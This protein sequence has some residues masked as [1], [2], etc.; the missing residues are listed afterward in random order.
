M[1]DVFLQIA[2]ISI[3]AGWI[4]IA[5]ILLR[6]LFKKAPKW[7]NCLL[8]GIVG[9][10]LVF[11][12]S[13]E[14]ALSLIPS[15]NTFTAPGFANEPNVS[16][17]TGFPAVDTAVNDYIDS[18]IFEGVSVS[19]TYFSDIMSVL[20]VIWVVGII[21][22]L[23]YAVISY[24]R[25]R[26][27]M[28]TS[29]PLRDNIRQSENVA[30]PFI[31]GIIKPK[32]YLPYSLDSDEAECIIAHEKAHLKRFDHIIKPLAFVILS[33][34]WFNPLIW[35]SYILLCRDI[36]LAC[37]EKVINSMVTEERQEYSVALLQNSVNRRT[38]SACPLAFGE[39]GIKERVKS[40]MSY[41]KPTLWIILIAVISCIIASV[42]F[43]TNPKT[44]SLKLKDVYINSATITDNFNP[45][46]EPYDLSEAEKLSLGN[47]LEKVKA[48]KKETDVEIGSPAYSISVRAAGMDAIQIH[49]YDDNTYPCI[50]YKNEYYVAEDKSFN[51]NI[52][53]LCMYNNRNSAVDIDKLISNAV[54]ERYRS[55]KPTGYIDVE[56]HVILGTES[57][58]SAT[59]SFKAT[60][61]TVY[62][63][64]KHQAYS[65][66]NNE[67]TSKY[68]IDC[69][70]AITFSIDE[71][72]AYTLKEFQVPAEGELLK[73]SVKE[74]FPEN[75]AED[76][77]K[78]YEK[79]QKE[80][81]DECYKKAKAYITGLNSTETRINELLN[82]ICSSPAQSSAPGDYIAAHKYE[83]DEIIKYDDIALKFIYSEFLKGN[84][85]DLR[86]HVMA[87]IM[88]DLLNDEAI[89][90]NAKTGQEYF[91]AFLNN[92][93]TVR[94]RRG[95]DY[96]E[97]YAPRAHMALEMTGE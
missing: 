25:L 52:Y 59:Q 15:V 71:N 56:G 9:L 94:N 46:T 62:C 42:C 13:I 20:S 91:D 34:Y 67:L 63:V 50:Y 14:S 1:N 17:E 88:R 55:D 10:R 36:E 23:L 48:K 81:N 80:L 40:V 72:N 3:T 66:Y 5:V 33:V 32:I 83:Y 79:Y 39:V 8:W 73:S 24:I 30:S 74:I 19:S 43:L 85:T 28:G 65:F 22:M 82:V 75:I 61:T 78:H 41:K 4:V 84:Q 54:M 29:T 96:M 26:N 2:N 37:D 86:G 51:N 12:F 90:L 6:L 92:A 69:P 49:Y 58:A 93:E 31:L 77:L 16:V 11:P 35:V 60:E 97:K 53:M 89:S 45:K 68:G 76:I 18:R 21:I 27:K 38:I 57:K 87:L 7:I 95:D 64:V 44:D 70:A 47:T